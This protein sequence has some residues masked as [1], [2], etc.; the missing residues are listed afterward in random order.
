M[1]ERLVQAN[2]IEIWTED[3]GTPSDPTVLMICGGT[4]QAVMTPEEFC[5]DL[6]QAG[7][8][9]IR[10][11]HRDTGLSTCID[12]STEPYTGLDLAADA[13]GVLDAYEVSSAHI[14][15][16]SM[17]GFVA[18]TVAINFPEKVLTLTSIMSSPAGAPM[19]KE[20]GD[21]IVAAATAQ[22]DEERIARFVEIWRYFSGPES[23]IE[24]ESVR[25][26]EKRII[27]RARN[28][29]AAWNHGLVQWPDRTDDL[30]KIKAATLVIH[31]LSDPIVPFAQGEATAKAIPGARLVPVEGMGH[32]FGPPVP[33]QVLEAILEHTS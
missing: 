33:S 3:F 29:Q 22:D 17:G 16:V 4:C 23:P 10:Y 12:F 2:G 1:G 7:R 9:V 30:A 25:D 15:G 13:V 27:A 8:H 20:A 24:E 18:Q 26:R 28:L 5:E 14:V 11:D 6:A 21:L 19:P 32:Y 31:G